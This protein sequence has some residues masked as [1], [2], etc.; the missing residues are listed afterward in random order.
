MQATTTKDS[1]LRWAAKRAATNRANAQNSTGP[2]TEPGKQR[3]SLNA[4]GHGL[5]AQTAVLPSEDPIA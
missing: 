1:V 5:T 4:L 2:R 3:S